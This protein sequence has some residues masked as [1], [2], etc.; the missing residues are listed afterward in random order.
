MT[1]IGYLRPGSFSCRNPSVGYQVQRSLFVL[2]N[3]NDGGLPSGNFW[4]TW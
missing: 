3:G 4:S 1:N 2:P